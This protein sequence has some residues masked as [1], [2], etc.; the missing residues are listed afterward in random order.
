MVQAIARSHIEFPRLPLIF[1][2]MYCCR[3]LTLITPL[4]RPLRPFSR[5]LIVSVCLRAWLLKSLDRKSQISFP[6]LAI[7]LTLGGVRTL[8]ITSTAMGLMEGIKET[9]LV[10]VGEHCKAIR[11]LDMQEQ[12]KMNFAPPD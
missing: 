8:I 3:I 2:L 9:N 6:R 10:E 4:L 1:Y 7:V 5:P 12:V 11:K